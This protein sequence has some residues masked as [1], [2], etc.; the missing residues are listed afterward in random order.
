LVVLSDDAVA[1]FSQNGGTEV[2]KGL[3][4][5]DFV[6]KIV[7]VILGTVFRLDVKNHLEILEGVS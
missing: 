2:G 1:E 7:N 5:A 4:V 3:N 6:L